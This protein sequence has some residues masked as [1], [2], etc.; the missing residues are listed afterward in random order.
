VFSLVASGSK[1]SATSSPI[2]MTVKPAAHQLEIRAFRVYGPGGTGDWFVTLHNT[3]SV[4]MP[5]FGWRVAVFL[6]HVKK[7]IQLPLPAATLGA[8]A[9]VTVSGTNLTLPGHPRVVRTGPSFIAIP[10]GFEVFAP[11]NSVSD[12]AGEV[13]GPKDAIEGNGVPI[14]GK[15]VFGSQS[16][17]ERKTAQGKLVDPGNTARD[18]L[19]KSFAK[20]QT[21]HFLSK[22]PGN[23]TVGGRY[24]VRARGG[25]SGKHVKF[26]AR[27]ACKVR[28]S[29]VTFTRVGTC[30][31]TATQA[32]SVSYAAGAPVSQRIKVRKRRRHKAADA[33]GAVLPGVTARR[34]ARAGP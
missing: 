29:L 12:R 6:P 8:G 2:A 21:I 18:V 4:T 22:P 10:G 16:A 30:V 19:F 11:D 28:G 23:A 9:E 14:P 5:L 1:G 27:G 17:F 13:G 24:H 15:K 33:S 32:G 31:I 20:R 3:T 26:S 25:A 7:P 34:P